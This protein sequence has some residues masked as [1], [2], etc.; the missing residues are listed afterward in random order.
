MRT[1]IKPNL[2]G[3]DGATILSASLILNPTSVHVSPDFG[4]S[5]MFHGIQ[6]MKVTRPYN[7]HLSWNKYLVR[8]N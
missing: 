5:N 3:L 2:S 6:G 7:A 1:V 4:S 8:T